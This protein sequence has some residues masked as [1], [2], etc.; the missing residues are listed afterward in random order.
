MNEKLFKAIPE[1][2]STRTF[3]SAQ[4]SDA[5]VNHVGDFVQGLAL[6]F[7]SGA[8][9][10]F[11]NASPGKGLYNNGIAPVNNI[12]LIAETDLVSVSK[13]GFAGE[14]VMLYATS[15][16]L[17]TCWF[18][19]YKLSELGKYIDGIATKERLQE[20]AFGYGYGNH[21]DVGKRVICCIPFGNGD[22]ASKRVID[23][24]MG[25]LGAHR[26][27]LPELLEE[28]TALSDIPSDITE[29]LD[30]AR[31]A[32]SAGNS[33]MWRF[34][35]D[36]NTK[37]LTVAKP[38]GYKHFK[39][40]HP[41]VDIGICAAHIWLGLVNKGY[42]LNIKAEQLE[43]RAFWSFELVKAPRAI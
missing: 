6:P 12:A 19:H 11:F 28:H 43:D 29:M 26:K 9:F 36:K 8:E 40:E 42:E 7:E 27:P 21:H 34:G 5:E 4:L 15:I 30:A 3:L 39:W 23:R 1:R 22:A 25:K 33:Q 37:M 14:L 17:A 2:H 18:G 24:I 13:T 38:I 16:G 32:P 10:R 41:D 31:L 20:S 35:F